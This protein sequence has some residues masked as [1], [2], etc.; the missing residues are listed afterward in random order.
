MLLI[1]ITHVYMVALLGSRQ[2]S[3]RSS[4]YQQ[5]PFISRAS[6]SSTRKGPGFCAVPP[7]QTHPL[8]QG[9]SGRQLL[10]C[11]CCQYLARSWTYRRNGIKLW[12]ILIWNFRICYRW[13]L[14]DLF[15]LAVYEL[16]LIEA[17][18]SAECSLC[19]TFHVLYFF[20]H[21]TYC[22]LM[23]DMYSAVC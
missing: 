2:Y 7:V 10:H 9:L 3:S 21:N 23:L 5:V 8:P 22:V 20:H 12:L 19:S 13:A 6:R 4:V 16:A 14:N 17:C 15:W 11:T 18:V 1:L